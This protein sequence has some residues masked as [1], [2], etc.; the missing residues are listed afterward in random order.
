MEEKETVY[1]VMYHVHLGNSHVDGVYKD[2]DAANNRVN[3][4]QT[5]I[6]MRSIITRPHDIVCVEEREVR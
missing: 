3:E 1:L 6:N 5:L 2:K 4:L